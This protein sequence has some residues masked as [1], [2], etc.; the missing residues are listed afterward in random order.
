M[1]SLSGV[2]RHEPRVRIAPE[3]RGTLGGE[4]TQ[5]GRAYGLVPDWWQSDV[6]DDW[7]AYKEGEQWASL[8]AGLT[9]PR[10]NGKN[11]ILEIWELY[12]SAVMGRRIVH[13][14]HEVKTARKAFLRVASFFEDQRR[15]PDLYRRVSKIRNTN[16]QEAVLLKNGGSIEFIARSKSSGRGFTADDLVCDEAQELRD[17]HMEALKP[18]LAAAPSGNPQTVYTGTPPLTPD[19]APVWFRMRENTLRGEAGGTA[20]TEFGVPD[21]YDIRKQDRES[22]LL[23]ARKVNPAVPGRI[24]MAVIEDELDSMSPEGFARERL[25]KW[26]TVAQDSSLVAPADWN[27]LEAPEDVTGRLVMGVKF[28]PSGDLVAA[29]VAV[30]PEEGPI[31]VAGLRLASTAEGVQWVA[32]VAKAM[33]GELCQ[34]VIDGRSGVENLV[35]T[36][37]EAG[38]HAMSKAKPAGRRVRMPNA[39]EYQDAHATFLQAIREQQLLHDGGKT[40]SEQIGHAKKRP[41]GTGGGWGWAGVGETDDVTMLDAATLAYWGARTTTRRP[42]R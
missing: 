33:G 1:T 13:T 35:L 5:M 4:A 11:G 36:L 23:M 39:T 22:I 7:L 37:K 38:I 26:P 29:A 12:K 41:I 34:I 28:A 9:V 40:L 16:G 14:A 10:Q 19:E 8:G 27:M 3:R 18:I 31:H 2:E 24:S 15:Y 17:E 42:K 32:T 21:D 30:R 20:W 25:G 6:L